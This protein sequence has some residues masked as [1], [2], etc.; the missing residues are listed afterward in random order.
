[1]LL[2][3]Q[4]YWLHSILAICYYDNR[5]QRSNRKISASREIQN[6]Q[7]AHSNVDWTRNICQPIAL[8]TAINGKDT[9]T[10]VEM[11]QQLDKPQFIMAMQK[12]ISDHEKRKHWKLFH[13]S[14][15]KGAKTI[16]EIWSFRRKRDNIIGKMKKYKA[17]IYAHVGMQEKGI[18]YWETYAP[19]VQWMSVRIMLPLSAIKNLHTKSIDFVLAYAQANIDVD[20][21]MELPQGFNVGLKAEDMF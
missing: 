8:I 20:T 16:M 14:E 4:K 13:R 10:Y 2:N 1:M 3:N 6:V 5:R 7:Q 19:V 21:Y 9:F 15:T 11:K 12:E 18:N 17:R